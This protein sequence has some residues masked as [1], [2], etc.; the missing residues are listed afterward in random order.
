MSLIQLNSISAKEVI[1]QT[2]AFTT[3][4]IVYGNSTN[5]VFYA[6]D[7]T[8]SRMRRKR[9][10]LDHLGNEK[11]IRRRETEIV[12]KFTQLLFAGWTPWAKDVALAD[13]K[14]DALLTH[15]SPR[16]SQVKSCDWKKSIRIYLDALDEQLERKTISKATHMTYNSYCRSLN[17]FFEEKK[18]ED[19]H[20]IDLPLLN[21]FLSTFSKCSVKYCNSVKG[22]LKTLFTWFVLNGYIASSPAD[23][24]KKETVART[25]GRETLTDDE[26]NTLFDRLRKADRREFLLACM[27]EYYCYIRPNELYQL[28]VENLNLQEQSVF[29]P[30]AISK[31]KRDGKVTLP[32]EVVDLM[33]ELDIPSQP[34]NFYVF[35]DRMQCCAKKGTPKQ[36]GR[37]WDNHV[38]C[39]DGLYPELKKRGIV[40]YSL[41]NTGITDM[42]ESGIASITVRD[43]A[44]HS[45]ISTTEIYARQTSLKAPDALK[46]YKGK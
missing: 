8:N 45:N 38:A 9:I 35:G 2:L 10:R 41:K 44:R 46:N 33:I 13:E 32:A 14:T 23:G 27:M 34:G 24:L 19:L 28:K 11:T 5:L 7:S 37:Y 4:R 6:Y 3:P 15:L 20:D 1:D 43:Q 40:F 29:I 12:G 18:V 17:A 16:K 31:N 30:A 22:F 26:R 21:Q 36:F 42:L 39:K 25:A